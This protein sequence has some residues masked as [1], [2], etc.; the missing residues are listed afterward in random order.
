MTQLENILG[1]KIKYREMKEI[2]FQINFPFGIKLK[3]MKL[4][5][6][7]FRSVF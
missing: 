3:C 5:S 6:K 4:I 7:E 1:L 2:D